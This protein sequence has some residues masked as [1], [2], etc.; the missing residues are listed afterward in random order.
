MKPVSGLETELAIFGQAVLSG[1]G[2]LIFYDILRVFRRIFSHGILWVSLEDFLYG[3]LV[4]GF[5]FLE[6]CR[7]N[8]GVIRGY[9]LLGL[10]LGALLYQRL[11]SRYLM[12]HLTKGILLAKK[13]LKNIVKK[14]TIKKKEREKPRETEEKE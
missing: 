4:S 7:E 3:I 9:I 13:R 6:L 5:F 8:S 12:R 10:A 14:V 2:M 1:I 11:C